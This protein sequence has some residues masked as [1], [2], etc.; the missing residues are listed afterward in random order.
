MDAQRLAGIVAVGEVDGERLRDRDD[1]RRVRHGGLRVGHAQLERAVEG[2]RAQLPPPAAGVLDQVQ[3]A[4]VVLPG[5][6]LRRDALARQHLGD[7]RPPRRH[8]RIAAGVK[9]RVRGERGQLGKTRAQGV[10]DR[11]RAIGAAD[12]DVDLQGEDQLAA[13]DL[14]ELRRRAVVPGTTVELS[15]VGRERVQARAGE[16]QLVAGGG[17]QVAAGGGEL[18]R[19]LGGAGQRRQ[20]DLDLRGREARA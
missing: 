2:V 1:R 5:E 14:A 7:D 13:G 11:Q 10:V 8:P 15:L 9:R 20:H 18:R 16:P 12:G 6:Q 3:C 4:G 17:Q 19:G